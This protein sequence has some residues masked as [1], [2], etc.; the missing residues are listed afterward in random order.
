MEY[1]IAKVCL[2]AVKRDGRALQ[3]VPDELKTAEVCIKAMAGGGKVFWHI[4]ETQQ[5]GELDLESVKGKNLLLKNFLEESLGGQKARDLMSRILSKLWGLPNEYGS[6]M[7]P[8]PIVDFVRQEQAQTIFDPKTALDILRNLP[9]DTQVDVVRRVATMNISTTKV[10]PCLIRWILDTHI[11]RKKAETL[12]SI[13]IAKILD[14]A[15]LTSGKEIFETLKG[16]DPE[17]A[18]KL[19]SRIFLFAFDDVRLLSDRDI[20]MIIQEIDRPVLAKALKGAETSVQDW[21]FDNMSTQAT[22]ERMGRLGWKMPTKPNRISS[23]LSS[24]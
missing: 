8:P 20:Q 10:F 13:N 21:I 1:R 23:R 16:K 7:N 6:R 12:S 19:Y 2:A 14:L 18:K 24:I 15:E 11:L 22:R 5:T 9:C 4:P 3:F 17:L